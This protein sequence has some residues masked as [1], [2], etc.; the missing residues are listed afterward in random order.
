[1]IVSPSVL[2][3][4]QAIQGAGSKD[5]DFSEARRHMEGCFLRTPHPPTPHDRSYVKGSSQKQEELTKI[6]GPEGNHYVL[7]L[8]RDEENRVCTMVDKVPP[9]QT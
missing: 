4:L 5:L 3:P 7:S 9:S 6:L 2:K 8:K 1:M